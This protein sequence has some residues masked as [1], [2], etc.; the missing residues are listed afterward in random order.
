MCGN[1]IAMDVSSQRDGQKVSLQNLASGC[2]R[3]TK[4]GNPIWKSP[5]SSKPSREVLR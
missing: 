3:H 5:R 1:I 4:C 2:L